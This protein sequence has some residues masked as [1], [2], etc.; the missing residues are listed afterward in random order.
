MWIPFRESL[1]FI[2]YF[3]ESTI[4]SEEI[5]KLNFASEVASFAK[6][7][8]KITKSLNKSVD[9]DKEEEE[10]EEC[11]KDDAVKLTGDLQQV[12]DIWQLRQN[13]ICI[14]ALLSISSFAY[15]LLDLQIERELGSV[16][17]NTIF[18]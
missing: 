14:M 10:E 4:T 16:I 15:Y 6:F 11:E 5:D 8:K 12:L 3:N 18:S 7:E 2:A 1:K 17:S 9:E 13:M